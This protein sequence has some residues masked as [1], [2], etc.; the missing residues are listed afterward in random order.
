MLNRSHSP[1][2]RFSSLLRSL[3]SAALD[4][5][6]T[7]PSCPLSV[8][9]SNCRRSRQ[10]LSSVLSMSLNRAFSNLKLVMMLDCSQIQLEF[11]SLRISPSCS[12]ALQRLRV[13]SQ[14]RMFLMQHLCMSPGLRLLFRGARLKMSVSP[15][16]YRFL[17]ITF[18]SL[19]NCQ[20]QMTVLLMI[21]MWNTNASRKRCLWS[22]R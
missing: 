5:D 8:K 6:R 17:R 11:L 9:Q 1:R 16:R 22:H 7:R 18:P 4:S 15:S 20:F 3:W 2:L 13:K 10:P 14:C 19:S 21:P 12:R